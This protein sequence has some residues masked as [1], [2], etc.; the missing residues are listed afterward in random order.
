MPK[1]RRALILLAAI[2]ALLA[3]LLVLIPRRPPT[4]V[5]AGREASRPEGQEPAPQPAPP[6]AAAPQPPYP[7]PEKESAPLRPAPSVARS[8]GPAPAERAAR[9]AIVIDDVGYSLEGLK[10]FLQLPYPLAFSVLPDLPHSAE[11]AE[12]IDAAGRQLL[13]HLPMEPAGGADPGPGAVLT[14]QSDREIEEL[15]ADRFQSFPQAVGLNNHMGSRATADR[16][17]M[18]VVLGFLLEHGKFFLDSRTTPDTLGLTLGR[19]LGARVLERDVFLD[20]E[21]TAAYVAQ[22]LEHGARI[23]RSRGYAVLIGH[24]QNAELASELARRLPELE[25]R[26]IQIV[27]PGTLAAQ[28]EGRS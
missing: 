15:L 27:P 26:G 10:A 6:Q 28:S 23:A 24:V 4:R 20:N 11:A 18:G 14:T 16:R 9:V 25:R 8:R 5:G 17:V 21:N 13:V 19:Q 22:A 7:I 2:A 3:I 1:T 12:L